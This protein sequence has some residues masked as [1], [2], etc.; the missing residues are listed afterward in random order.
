[1]DK[2]LVLLIIVVPFI[3]YTEYGSIRIDKLISVYD[4]DTFRADIDSYPPIIGK[5]I[6]IRIKDIDAPEISAQCEIE[7]KIAIKARDR[8]KKLLESAIVVELRN[9]ERGNFFRL[10]ADVYIDGINLGNLIL[11]EGLAIEY[12]SKSKDYWC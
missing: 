7:K 9:I 2:Y 6:R 10:I 3:A 5:N 12:S 1:M 4:G 11:N 8:T